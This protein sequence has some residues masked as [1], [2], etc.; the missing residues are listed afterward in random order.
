M[1]FDAGEFD[2]I[3]VG[4]GH[5]GCEAALAG[6]RLGKKTLLLTINLDT[7]GNMACNPNI[8]GT[9][10]GQLV[11]EVDALGGEIARNADKT[12]LQSKMLN[13][14]KGPA[15]HSLRAQIDRRKYQEEMKQTLEKQNGL[16]LKQAE[17]IEL[18]AINKRISRVVTS[19]GAVYSTKTVILCTGTYLKGKIIIGETQRSGGPDGDQASNELSESLKKLGIELIRLKTGTPPRINARWIDFDKMERQDG[20]KDIRFFSFENEGKKIEFEQI[21]CHLTWTTGKTKEIIEANLH[22]SPLFSGKIEGVGP[23]YCPSI[24]DKIVRFKDKDRHQVFIEPMGKETW[25]MYVQ[26]MSS[27]LPEDVQIEM[28]KSIPGLEDSS[29]MRTAYAIEYDAILPYQIKLSLE[30]KI[31]SGLFSA[32]Q[33]NGSSGYEEA[34]AQG[35]IAGINAVRYID[36]EAPLILDRSHAYIGVLIDDLV[37]KGTKEPYRMMTSRAEYRLILRQDN[38][39][40]RLTET[41]YRTGLINEERYEDFKKKYSEIYKETERLKNI[42]V[43]PSKEVQAFLEKKKSAPIKSGIRL[44]ELLKRPEIDYLSLKE[45]DT[46]QPELE[47]HIRESI[48]IRIKY[49]G[50][51]NKQ[52]EDIRRFKKKEEKFI[53]EDIDYDAIKG[54]RLEAIQKLKR[55]K[56]LSIGQASRISGVSPADINVLIISME[57]GKRKKNDRF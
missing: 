40:E 4:A 19:T 50:Y 27:S 6:A 33:I 35:I 30:S 44:S 21:P 25:E 52:L 49:E 17:A 24:E 13:L 16:Y 36:K 48:E 26:G 9:A 53:P 7:V 54:L 57:V 43:A 39:D 46:D 22:R 51:I 34:A 38:A 2:I 15:V 32:G 37:T 5:A 1:R 28:I 3:V 8:G 10:K 18:E 45:I 31:I 42:I 23:R 55:Y 14:T 47:K 20:D 41:G 12:L 29:I 56:P 11:L